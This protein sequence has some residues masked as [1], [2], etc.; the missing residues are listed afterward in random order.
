MVRMTSEIRMNSRREWRRADRRV[1]RESQRNEEVPM[2][3]IHV[4]E[5]NSIGIDH[6]IK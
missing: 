6:L 1:N 4:Y 3:E 2:D 5:L